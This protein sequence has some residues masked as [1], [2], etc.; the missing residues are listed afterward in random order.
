MSHT[1]A[2][3]NRTSSDGAAAPDDGTRLDE[4]CRALLADPSA[5]VSSDVQNQLAA[6]YQRVIELEDQLADRTLTG[7]ARTAARRELRGRELHV[8]GL[9]TSLERLVKVITKEAARS[10]LGTHWARQELDDLHQ[11]GMVAALEAAKSFDP[12]RG[13]SVSQW[14]AREVRHALSGLN[15]EA[16][17]GTRPKS[18]NRVARLAHGIL[19]SA[20]NRG[21]RL[22]MR[23]LQQSVMERCQ[24]QTTKRIRATKPDISH[25]DVEALC[26]DR[27][28]RQ[29]LIAAI[30]ELP[31]VLTT[32]GGALSLDAP[33]GDDGPSLHQQVGGRM[34]AAEEDEEAAETFRM[35]RVALEGLPALHVYAVQA[36]CRNPSRPWRS[37]AEE[38]QMDW[39]EV[40]AAVRTG[41]ARVT[42]PHAQFASFAPDVP[43]NFGDAPQ[44][45]APPESRVAALLRQRDRIAQG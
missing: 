30:N 41:L 44:P 6:S 11:D 43:L 28:S 21:E 3:T 22:T 1:T 7:R 37:I 2:K 20:E 35:M 25:A 13:P 24:E 39:T 45:A 15:I 4:V 14:V 5:D 31:L 18:W 23:Q 10:R 42:S 40:K 17:G 34:A 19:A 8:A 36:H 9:M 32:S 27:L 29:G 26:H 33:A 38:V 12:E 16:G